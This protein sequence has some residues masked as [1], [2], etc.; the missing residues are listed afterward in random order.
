MIIVID[1]YNLLK[2]LKGSSFITEQQRMFFVNELCLYA[3]SKQHAIIT[4]FDGGFSSW[5]SREKKGDVMIV[6][7]GTRSSADDYI[8]QYLVQQKGKEILLVSSDGDLNNW[9]AKY[10]FVSIDSILFY[11]FMKQARRTKKNK[12]N[13]DTTITKIARD[14]TA[15]VDE[16]MYAMNTVEDV[17]EEE[18]MLSRKKHLSR[19]LT[20]NE[21][22]LDKILRKL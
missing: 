21:R 16:L 10:S 12:K 4:V 18:G 7:S 14:T 9:A 2:Q 13:Y 6:Y 17:D 3:K 11:D 1:A 15:E 8:K 22:R 5:P 20:K 19:Q